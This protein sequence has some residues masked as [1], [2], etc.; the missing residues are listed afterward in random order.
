MSLHYSFFPTWPGYRR[1]KNSTRPTPMPQAQLPHSTP[2][3]AS[4]SP[5]ETMTTNTKKK[6]R[7]L[8]VR[9]AEQERK[10]KKTITG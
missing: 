4:Q 5:P 1:K 7:V 8:Y 3:S 9:N 2:S 10:K 6:K